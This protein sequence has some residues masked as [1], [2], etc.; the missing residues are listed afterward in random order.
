[1]RP[2]AICARRHHG[3]RAH[4]QNIAVAGIDRDAHL[5]SAPIDGAHL[6]GLAVSHRRGLRHEAVHAQDFADFVGRH[7]RPEPGDGTS[8]QRS[9][10]RQGSTRGE[11]DRDRTDSGFD[12]QGFPQ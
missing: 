1:M 11:T 5:E 10:L 9:G 7:D 4:H 6:I 2:R 3:D 12:E 8:R